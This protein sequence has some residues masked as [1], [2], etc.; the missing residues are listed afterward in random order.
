VLRLVHVAPFGTDHAAT[1]LTGSCGGSPGVAC[2]VIWDLTHNGQ[3]ASLTTN[4]LAGPVHLVLRIAY[5][6]ALALLIRAVLHRVINRITERATDTLLPQF[7][8][9]MASSLVPSRLLP[10]RRRA[11]MAGDA[12]ADFA[13]AASPAGAVD[14]ADAADAAGSADA[15]GPADSANAADAAEP[16]VV[17]D[18]ADAADDIGADAPGG[19]PVTG[20]AAEALGIRAAQAA[21]GEAADAVSY[22]AA[23]ESADAVG[24]GAADAIRGRAA[25]AMG[26]ASGR[27]AADASASEIAA[28]AASAERALVDER[29]HQR[30]RALGSILRSTASA[31]VFG[32]AGVVVL[33]DL[34]INLAPLLASAGVVGFAIGFGAQN[35]VRDYLS[36]I[37]ML[38]EDQ[39]GVGD[40]ITVND[41]TGTVETVTLRITRLRDVNGIVWHVRNGTIEQVGNESQGWARAVIDFP[42]PY[43]ADLATIRTV[44]SDTALTLWNEP[45]WRA[46][47]LEEPEVWGA[48]E[49]SSSEVTMRI[50]V[51]TAPLRQWEVEREMRARVKAALDAAGITPVAEDTAAP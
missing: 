45:T 15:A 12:A 29:R 23:D 40:V 1:T 32:I 10:R 39:Y 33:G 19:A 49:V 17:A 38:L 48:Q 37:F 6:L 21:G 18:A 36:G 50:V 16:A 20:P 11:E 4:F 34:G 43:A 9:G 47:M 26:G 31:V 7:R 24:D 2:R 13:D 25:E 8:T 46:V 51:K 22:Q 27:A 28:A 5:V 44:L 14:V 3:L 41:A 42:V 35:L 30:V